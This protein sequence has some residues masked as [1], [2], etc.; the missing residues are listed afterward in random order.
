MPAPASSTMRE[1]ITA[2]AV[3][4]LCVLGGMCGCWEAGSWPLVHIATH[5]W[6]NTSMGTSQPQPH[7]SSVQP[8]YTS[9]GKTKPITQ[10]NRFLSQLLLANMMV[11]HHNSLAPD[12]LRLRWESLSFLQHL[13]TT[14]SFPTPLCFSNTA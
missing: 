1:E 9:I 8:A 11:I 12:G 6:I 7:E 4:G 3:P 14:A 10:K 13:C 5:P 2:R